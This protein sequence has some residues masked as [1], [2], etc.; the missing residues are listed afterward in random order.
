[1]TVSSV[2]KSSLGLF[3][4]PATELDCNR[5]G[6]NHSCRSKG[7][8]NRSGCS[9]GGSSRY[10]RPVATGHNWS[11]W[12]PVHTDKIKIFIKLSTVQ[13]SIL[14]YYYKTEWVVTVSTCVRGRACTSVCGRVGMHAQRVGEHVGWSVQHAWWET[15]SERPRMCAGLTH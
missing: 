15:V 4:K 11:V 3:S 12:Q 1:M 9:C 13:P 2:S 5:F 10:K 14:C 7:L 6:P 8:R